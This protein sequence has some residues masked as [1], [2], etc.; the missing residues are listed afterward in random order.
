MFWV[1]WVSWVSWGCLGCLGC[2][3]C[4]WGWRFNSPPPPPPP[5][6]KKTPQGGH[7]GAYEIEQPAQAGCWILGFRVPGIYYIYIHIYIYIY[8]HMG[9]SRVFFEILF[10]RVPYYTT[11]SKRDANAENY[12]F[13]GAVQDVMVSRV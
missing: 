7:G 4:V 5:L 9:S 12:L 11:N 3:G 13:L 6:K 2:F 8:I 10:V 1:F